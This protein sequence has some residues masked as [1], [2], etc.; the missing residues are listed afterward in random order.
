MDAAAFL[1][2]LEAKP[3]LVTELVA[4]QCWVYAP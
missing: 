1:A 3:A 4:S 2:D